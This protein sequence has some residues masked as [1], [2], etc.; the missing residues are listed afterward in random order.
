MADCNSKPLQGKLFCRHRN[1]VVGIKVEDF[2]KHKEMHMAAL[3]QCDLH[4]NEEDLMEWTEGDFDDIIREGCDA[5]TDG[6]GGKDGS[7]YR[8][9][10]VASG[11]VIVPLL[12]DESMLSCARP[13]R[14]AIQ[15]ERMRTFDE[16]TNG[17]GLDCP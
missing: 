5:G 4:V 8:T 9:R 11:I 12:D 16:S 3:R 1:T 17:V 10:R 14:P 15:F 13:S 2:A 7:G 6:T